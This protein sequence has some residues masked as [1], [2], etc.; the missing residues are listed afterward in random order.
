M[1]AFVMY[2]CVC[3]YVRMY[4]CVYVCLYTH[5]H[6]HTYVYLLKAFWKLAL[7]RGSDEFFPEIIFYFPVIRRNSPL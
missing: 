3:M 5:T 1:Y 7:E 2:V 4:V 6:T